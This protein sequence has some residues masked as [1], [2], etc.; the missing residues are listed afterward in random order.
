[1]SRLAAVIL[2]LF[3]SQCFA[4]QVRVLLS[5]TSDSVKFVSPGPVVLSTEQQK[6]FLYYSHS[7]IRLQ[8][9]KGSWHVSLQSQKIKENY[10][11]EGEK[12]QISSLQLNWENSL[13]DFPIQTVFQDQKYF[14]IGLMSMDRYLAG[15]VGREMPSSWPIEALKAQ[16]VASRSYALWKLS[17]QKNEIYDLQPSVLD[18]VFQLVK[19]YESPSLPPKVELAI[20][21]TSGDYLTSTDNKMIKTFFHSDCGGETSLPEEV[22]GTNDKM[23]STARDR[24]CQSRKSQW[25]SFWNS[26]KIQG[27]LM[28]ELFLPNHLQLLDIVVRQQSKSQRA[29]WVDLIFS[30]GIFKRIRGEDL[31]RL[32]GYDKIKSTLF[33]V[34]KKADGWQFEGRGFGHGVG[35]CQHGAKSMAERGASYREILAHYYPSSILKNKAFDP[36]LKPQ[37]ISSL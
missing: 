24:A 25:S 30:K 35:M 13:V 11:I 9:K 36:S 10:Q 1:M 16:V 31:R 27:R 33:A 6:I 4:D 18:Q 34:S 26:E 32:F 23:A 37:K 15:V 28:T 3:S 21:A 2:L 29:E 7:Q 8:N 22:W 20:S 14:I 19:T 17:S 5:K 12:L